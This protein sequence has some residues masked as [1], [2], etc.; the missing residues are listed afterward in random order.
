MQGCNTVNEENGL[1]ISTIFHQDYNG[2]VYQFD[3]YGVKEVA[4]FAFDPY[5]WQNQNPSVVAYEYETL[6]ENLQQWDLSCVKLVS[7]EL[8]EAAYDLVLSG[9][10]ACTGRIPSTLIQDVGAFCTT[11]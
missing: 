8:D 11:Y 3:G 10:G 6:M 2:T 1:I 4:T 9:D 5:A 7:S